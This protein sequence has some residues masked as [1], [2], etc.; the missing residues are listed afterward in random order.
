MLIILLTFQIEGVFVD[1]V[2]AMG[3]EKYRGLAASP[4]RMG[5]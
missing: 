3:G 5:K 1:A 2:D 4:S